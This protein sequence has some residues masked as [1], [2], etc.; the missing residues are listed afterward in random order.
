ML[1]LE[2]NEGDELDMQDDLLIAD[3][4]ANGSVVTG[5][6]CRSAELLGEDLFGPEAVDAYARERADRRESLCIAPQC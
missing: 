3:G 2:M 4:G 5:I 6:P 1:R